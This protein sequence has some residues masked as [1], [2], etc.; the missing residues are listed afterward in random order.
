[1]AVRGCVR[2]QAQ[3]KLSRPNRA[4]NSLAAQRSRRPK[5]ERSSAARQVFCCGLRLRVGRPFVHRGVAYSGLLSTSSV[6]APVSFMQA[7]PF[8]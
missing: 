8:F 4:L 2:Y 6:T 5:L 3:A 7:M 1:M